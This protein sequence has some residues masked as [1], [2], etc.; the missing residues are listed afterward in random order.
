[1]GRMW[2]W[3]G[4][5][6]MDWW[7]QVVA[8]DFSGPFRWLLLLD[9]DSQRVT[10]SIGA[11]MG[12]RYRHQRARLWL[13][14]AGGCRG[15][16]C[17][18]VWWLRRLVRSGRS[19]GPALHAV[20]G[21]EARRQAGKALIAAASLPYHCHQDDDDGDGMMAQVLM[22]WSL[23]R[24]GAVSQVRL[25]SRGLVQRSFQTNPKLWEAACA[26]LDKVGR[27]ELEER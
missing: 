14:R 24:W 9:E 16:G 8:E 6:G 4:C 20:P 17:V 10:L 25:R 7:L 1:M 21:G 15:L 23:C 19:A 2:P 18:C 13:M 11:G 22:A 5:Y 26:V 27:W 3:I 12:P